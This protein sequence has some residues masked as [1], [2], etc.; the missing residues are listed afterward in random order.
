M[1]MLSKAEEAK[2]ECQRNSENG[3]ALV[4]STGSVRRVGREEHSCTSLLILTHPIHKVMQSSQ[5]HSPVRDMIS[6]KTGFLESFKFRL[7]LNVCDT[8]VIGSASTWVQ[9]YKYTF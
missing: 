9:Q 3:G 8:G 5:A 6:K 2:P 4:S 7:N 1:L